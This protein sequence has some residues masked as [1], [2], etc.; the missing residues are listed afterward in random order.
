MN[1]QMIKMTCPFDMSTSDIWL[2][3]L[4]DWNDGHT[5]RDYPYSG[6]PQDVQEILQNKEFNP[7]HCVSIRNDRVIIEQK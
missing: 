6:Y 3:W 7:G 5:K 2:Q 1:P 4:I